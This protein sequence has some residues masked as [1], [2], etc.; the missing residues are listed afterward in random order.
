MTCQQTSTRLSLM[1]SIAHQNLTWHNLIRPTPEELNELQKKYEFHELDIEDCLSEQERPKIDEYDEYLFLVLHIPYYERS[2]RRIVKE[3]VHVFVGSDYLITL[4]DGHLN[5]L[6]SLWKE[7]ET[8]EE[9]KKEF[10]GEGTGYFLYELINNLFESGFPLVDGITRE[11]GK[12]EG[13]LFETEREKKVLRVILELKRSIIAMR[14]ILLPQRTL[15]AALEHKSKKFI[16]E[17]LDVYFDDVLDAIERQWSLLETSKEVI[18][19]LQDSHETWI[20]SKT[21][22]VIRVLTVFS[23]TLLPLTVITGFYG[24]NVH[25][26]YSDSPQAFLGIS[27]VL[28]F[29]LVGAL[30]YSMWKKWL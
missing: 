10:L 4:H 12:L 7:L 14:R 22:R 28:A 18:E 6:N 11:L 13:I 15:V 21:N 30:I 25:L 1:K 29:F 8:S 2:T 5:V 9:A 16:D 26:P 24:M 27:A 20:Q 3:E 17:E 19:A 23:V